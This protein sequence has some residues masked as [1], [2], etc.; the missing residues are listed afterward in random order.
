MKTN[1][2]K[3]GLKKISAVFLFT[4][5]SAL[6]WLII[7]LSNNYIVTLPFNIEIIEQPV[8]QTLPE[9]NYSIEAAIEAS[10]YKLL[11]YYLRPER[12]RGIVVSLKD[13]KYKKTED[14]KYSFATVTIKELIANLMKINANE[15]SIKEND[16][17]FTM[18]RLASKR[19][20]VV[21]K[22]NISF[23]SQFNFYGEP[24]VTPDSITISGAY[25]TIKDIY[26]VNTNTLTKRNVRSSLSQSVGL[27][28][29]DDVFSETKEVE[30]SIEVEKF[31]ES[32]VTIPIN[33][34]NISNIYL[35]PNEVKIRYIVAMKDYSN[36]SNLSFNVEIDSTD[37]RNRDRLPLKLVVS[38]SNTK[39]T[40][41][42]PS[43]VNYIM[44]K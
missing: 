2:D 26:F 34:L 42:S 18:Y 25:N 8:N 11:N 3:S 37:F 41:I 17:I 20:K 10:G 19:V 1:N 32:E 23:D 12:L 14:D 16:F 22:T 5:I 15:V 4:C 30:I 21:P 39:V 7:K 29:D 28:L 33:T 27:Q 40:S 31:T 36:I 13:T 38:P 35:F 44:T 43:E 9:N 24:S 6:M